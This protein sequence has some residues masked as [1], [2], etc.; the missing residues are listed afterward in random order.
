MSKTY[1]YMQQDQETG[2]IEYVRLTAEE[3]IEQM[4][5]SYMRKEKVEY[6]EALDWFIEY[7]KD[8]YGEEIINLLKVKKGEL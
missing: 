3:L 8:K 5:E 6:A 7:S 4:T 1:P 2:E